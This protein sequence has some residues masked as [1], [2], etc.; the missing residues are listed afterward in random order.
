MSALHEIGNFCITDRSLSRVEEILAVSKEIHH[1][2]THARLLNV[3]SGVHRKFERDI[4]KI[5]PD[6][7]I[8]SIDPSLGIVTIDEN[9]DLTTQGFHIECWSK[10]LISYSSA[11]PKPLLPEVLVYTGSRAIEYDRERKRLAVQT[12]GA[13]ASLAS[14]LPFR[15]E[16]F[17]LI[18]DNMGP[19]LY[20]RSDIDK[21]NY[22]SELQR[23]LRKDGKIYVSSLRKKNKEIL[24][25]LNMKY[26]PTNSPNKE[27]YIIYHDIQED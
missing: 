1:L 16:S 26:S 5:R 12:P 20:L 24:D 3:G 21:L 19:I 25:A 8:N 11:R 6:L 7:M 18:I 22:L 4:H 10:A 23:V 27:S 13:I 15:G 2:P 17:N 14:A 9:G